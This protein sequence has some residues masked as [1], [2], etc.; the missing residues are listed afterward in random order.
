MSCIS[1]VGMPGAGKSTLGVLLAK[2]LG[3]SFVDTDLLIQERAN[4]VLQKI[5]EDRGYQYLRE[6]EE[7]VITSLDLDNCVIATGGSAVYSEAAISHLKTLGPVLYIH[8]EYAALA[9][10]KL[11]LAE[12]GIAGPSGQ[13]LKDVYDE[14]A[15][16][17]ESYAD[18]IVRSTES[19]EGTLA[20]IEREVI[21]KL[22]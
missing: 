20:D 12:R 21:D 3:K 7:R 16:L 2:H 11:G 22:N 4:T 5:V 13:S 9:Q 15:P 10:R 19:I 6:L 1:L 8:V 17:Y 18:I 14:R